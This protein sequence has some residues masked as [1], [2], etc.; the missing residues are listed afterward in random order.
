MTNNH[1]VYSCCVA[2]RLSQIQTGPLEAFLVFSVLFFCF[3]F[4]DFLLFSFLSLSQSQ[5]GPV[6]AYLNHTFLAPLVLP[7]YLGYANI[8]V[9]GWR[10]QHES[11]F[12][13]EGFLA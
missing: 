13:A 9:Q 11:R 6:G 8:G 7:S 4:I 1:R 10:S 2:E 3:H 5:D 12:H